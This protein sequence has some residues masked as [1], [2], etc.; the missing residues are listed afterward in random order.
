M[1]RIV[2]TLLAAI[3]MIVGGL[4]YGGEEKSIPNQLQ[5]I[6]VTI[7][8]SG[9]TG[10]GVLFTR[11]DFKGSFINLVWTAGHVVED[12]RSQRVVITPDGSSRT[13]VEFGDPKIVT[14]IIED[15]RIVGRL[16]MDAEVVRYSN[17]DDGE[18]L[19][20]LKV[21]KKNFVDKTARFYLAT[22]IPDIGIDLLHV[23]S[24]KGQF[25]ANSL[26]GGIYSQHGRL[27]GK[28][29][30]DQTTC[31]AF[32]GSSGGGVFLKS[33][34]EYVGMLVRG[35]GE[36]FNLIVPIRRIQDWAKKA[37]VEW[38]LDPKIAMPS[39]EDLSKMPIEDVGKQFSNAPE[40][41]AKASTYHTWFN[42]FETE[43]NPATK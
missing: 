10:S 1:R 22:A 7:Q 30:Y 18:D 34:G 6:S 19:A 40:K 9:G 12:L 4:S 17:A 33:N 32:P 2:I 31:A 3:T 23:G 15:G 36:T 21:R 27:L 28:T 20:L 13:I 14:Q 24:L 25:G 35:A 8:S 11:K 37:K 29:V 42:S 5:D 38:A 39:D 41:A 26:T 43:T 16:E